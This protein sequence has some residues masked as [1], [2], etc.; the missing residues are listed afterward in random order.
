MPRA[1]PVSRIPPGGRL[2]EPE[3]LRLPVP[4]T[5]PEADSESLSE[6]PDTS[7]SGKGFKLDSDPARFSWQSFRA[8]ESDIACGKL[9]WQ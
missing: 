8:A 7:G 4:T 9:H 6:L 3:S 5:Q 1:G 2:G